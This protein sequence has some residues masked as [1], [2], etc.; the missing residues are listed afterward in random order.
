MRIAIINLSS[1]EY[2][3]VIITV[4]ICINKYTASYVIVLRHATFNA[5]LII[6]L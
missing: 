1:Y 3:H 4:I 6:Q 5:Y 2:S